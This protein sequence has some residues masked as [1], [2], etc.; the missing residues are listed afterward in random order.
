MITVSSIFSAG[1]LKQKVNKIN[2][3]RTQFQ[4]ALAWIFKNKNPGL[5]TGAY[6]KV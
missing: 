1:Q 5:S 2:I 4:I 6:T 3:I